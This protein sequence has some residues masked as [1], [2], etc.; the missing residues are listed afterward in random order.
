MT[1]HDAVERAREQE[2]TERAHLRAKLA[3]AKELLE[4]T[5]ANFDRYA[6][7]ITR[8]IKAFLAAK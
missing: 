2:A 3:E 7:P 8:E 5:V 4:R 6:M 1:L